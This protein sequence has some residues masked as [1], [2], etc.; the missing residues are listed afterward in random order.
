MEFKLNP[1]CLTG[2][3]PV[4]NSL[5]DENIRLASAVQLKTMLYLLR[6]VNDSDLSIEKMSD[7]LLYDKADILDALIFW[8]ERGLVIKDGQTP[9]PSPLIPEPT[10]TIKIQKAP[11]KKEEPETEAPQKK[12]VPTLDIPR[13]S[14]EQVAARVK[15]CA[16]L[17]TLFQEAQVILGKTIGY[18]GQA[19]LIMM[20]DGYGLPIEVILMAVQYAVDQK[21]TGYSQIARIGKIWCENEVNTLEAVDEY[22]SEHTI[23]D[24]TWAKLRQMTEITNRNPTEKQRKFLSVWVKEYGYN[25]DMIFYAYEES[26]DRTGK[27]SM[28]YMDK[29]I[30]NWHVAGVRTPTDIENVQKQWAERQQKTTGKNKTTDNAREVSYDIDKYMQNAINLKNVKIEND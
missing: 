15:E 16:E 7:A 27:M 19:V 5:V 26:I 1:L 8:Q 17:S 14:H 11:T 9:S 13:P 23:V 4:P 18:E 10:T 30:R 22:L 29:I 3:F 21:K 25:A 24:E 20:Y 28:P 6:H 12:S 2:I